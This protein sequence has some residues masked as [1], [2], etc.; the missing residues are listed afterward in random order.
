VS[1][2]QRVQASGKVLQ[3][4]GKRIGRL[5][6]K[7]LTVSAIAG[8]LLVGFSSE[9]DATDM[10]LIHEGHE[11]RKKR[12]RWI[13]RLRRFSQIEHESNREP[14]CAH[15]SN[16]ICEN[17]RNLR[18]YIFLSVSFLPFVFLRVLRGP[19]AFEFWR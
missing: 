6:I 3:S 18:I 14:R 8:L 4:G 16:S 11:G 1:D 7:S 5:T 13:R 19:I 12:K 15:P 10:P 17:L 9:R 2:W